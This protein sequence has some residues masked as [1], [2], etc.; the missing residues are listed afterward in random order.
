MSENLLNNLL[1]YKIQPSDDST[2][3]IEIGN[4]NL[5]RGKGFWKFN[6]S[7]LNDTLYV[8]KI[9]EIIQKYKLEYNTLTNKGLVWELIKMEIRSY[10]LPYC[11]RKRK[12]NQHLKNQ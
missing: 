1:S 9:K 8:E 4:N 12:K 7:L 3:I 5:S 6:T 2:Q 10:T 11:V